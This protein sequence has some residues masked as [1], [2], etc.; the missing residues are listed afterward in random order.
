[1]LLWLLLMPVA[2]FI[3]LQVWLCWAQSHLKLRFK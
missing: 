3:T 1:M 2:A